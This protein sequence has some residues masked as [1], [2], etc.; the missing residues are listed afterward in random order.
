MTYVMFHAKKYMILF[1]N[2]LTKIEECEIVLK[3]SGI[4]HITCVWGHLML[5]NTTGME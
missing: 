1:I 2:F 5:L 4:A 3:L